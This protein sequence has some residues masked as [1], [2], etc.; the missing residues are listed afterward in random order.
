L[1]ERLLQTAARAAENGTPLGH[2][3]RGAS[4]R[5]SADARRAPSNVKRAKAAETDAFVGRKH[6]HNLVETSVQNGPDQPL[7][8]SGPLDHAID[9]V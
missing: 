5:M 4:D 6:P 2:G 8:Q 9:Q 1:P 3:Q 7:R